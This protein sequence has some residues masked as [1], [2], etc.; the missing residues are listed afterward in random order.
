M[1]I[2][3]TDEYGLRILTRIAK[4]DHEGLSISQLSEVEGL[5]NS[6]AA[7]I[8]R[9]LRKHGLINSIRGHQGGYVLA[10]P[11]TEITVNDAL[12]AL[13]G[14]LFNQS[15]CSNHAG[16]NT[17]CSNSVDCSLRSLWKLVQASL[18]RILDQITIDDLLDSEG[19]ADNRLRKI[20]EEVFKDVGHLNGLNMMKNEVPQ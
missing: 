6:Y 15:F 13:G 7:K 12:R 20:Y 18:D 2:N 19:K 1:K 5:S 9:A 4:S 11:A 16:Q 3:A 17:F 14:V 10:R 8:C